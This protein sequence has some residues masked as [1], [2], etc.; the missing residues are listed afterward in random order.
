M[1]VIRHY[2]EGVGFDTGKVIGNIDPARTHDLTDLTEVHA[3]G[4]DPAK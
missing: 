1:D 4:F 2:D 3:A